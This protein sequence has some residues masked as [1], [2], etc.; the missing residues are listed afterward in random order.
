[1]PKVKVHRTSPSLDMTPMVDLAFL[2]VTFF[3]LISKFA[4]E[5]VLVVDTPASISPEKLPESD[6]IQISIGNDG[7]VF[8]GVDSKST[9]LKLIDRISEKYGVAFTEQE[10][11]TFSLLPSFGVPISSLKGFLALTSEE[12]KTVPQP[13][14]PIDST[15]NELG[16]WVQQARYSNPKSIIAIKGDGAAEYATAGRV[17]SILQDKNVNRFN[18]VTDMKAK[19]RLPQ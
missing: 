15:R 19:P 14:I 2:L 16:D 11:E 5:E 12:Q 6:V 8:F 9:K 10:K 7:R 4:P 18:L 1:M 17:I 13:G 3:M